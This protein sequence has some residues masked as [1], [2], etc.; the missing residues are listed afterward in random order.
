M[1][2]DLFQRVFLAYALRTCMALAVLIG[3]MAVGGMAIGLIAVG[4]LAV[5][6]LVGK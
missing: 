6:I 5:G 2:T 4:G 1:N 3:I